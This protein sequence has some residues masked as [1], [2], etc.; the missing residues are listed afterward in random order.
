MFKYINIQQD[1]RT[2]METEIR[3]QIATAT[4]ESVELMALAF[5]SNDD[6]QIKKCCGQIKRILGQLKKEGR[7]RFFMENCNIN[8]GSTESEFLKNKYA[9]HLVTNDKDTV[10]FIKL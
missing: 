7:I 10:F 9:Q 1:D 3:F 8:N 2:I 5:N 4:V 6:I